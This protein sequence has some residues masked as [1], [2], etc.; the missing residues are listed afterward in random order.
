MELP[1]ARPL[2]RSYYDVS[3]VGS[4]PDRTTRTH[5]IWL[6]MVQALSTE[7]EACCRVELLELQSRRLADQGNQR[8]VQYI[9]SALQGGMCDLETIR[10]MLDLMRA[11][12]PPEGGHSSVW[13]SLSKCL[14]D[15]LALRAITVEGTYDVDQIDAALGR[16]YGGRWQD[17]NSALRSRIRKAMSHVIPEGWPN[18]TH[19]PSRLRPSRGTAGPPQSGAAGSNDHRALVFSLQAPAQFEEDGFLPLPTGLKGGAPS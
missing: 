16:L 9:Q 6:R 14:R 10:I 4:S 5:L 2:A 12:P 7:H 13:R 11:A 8:T 19:R 18:R 3:G 15:L 17:P 1:G